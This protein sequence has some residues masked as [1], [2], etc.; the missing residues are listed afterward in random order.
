MMG[1]LLQIEM[2]RLP[3]TLRTY[4]CLTRSLLWIGALSLIQQCHAQSQEAHSV[5]TNFDYFKNT[6]LTQCPPNTTA[7]DSLTDGTIA[8]WAISIPFATQ[9]SFCSYFEGTAAVVLP[10]KLTSASF[11]PNFPSYLLQA[12]SVIVSIVSIIMAT[13]K[14]KGDLTADM[15]LPKTFW[16]LLP[17][18]LARVV[19]WWVRWVQGALDRPHAPWLSVVLWTVPWNY[20]WLFTLLKRQSAKAREMV[21]EEQQQEPL[22]HS[23]Y[24]M[25][26]D[27]NSRINAKTPFHT[28]QYSFNANPVYPPPRPSTTS[29]RTKLSS[30]LIYHLAKWG[31]PIIVIATILHWAATAVF[32]AFHWLSNSDVLSLSYASYD[33]LPLF[34]SGSSLLNASLVPGACI[35][36]LRASTVAGG[37]KNSSSGTTLPKELFQDYTG[38]WLMYIMTGQFALCCFCFFQCWDYSRNHKRRVSRMLMLSCVAVFLSLIIPFFWCAFWFRIRKNIQVQYTV[39]STDTGVDPYTIVVFDLSSKWGYWDVRGSLDKRV[40]LGL[41]GVE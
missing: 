5:F 6:G 19:A 11:L 22:Y 26:S 24:E 12:I 2:S 33:P 40:I 20:V 34:S 15:T 14:L 4:S 35:D 1:T 30:P 3:A 17:Y 29:D 32:V 8:D 27:P 7:I 21:I 18:D 41:L 37:G 36:S 38:S 9:S 39:R 10:T 28:S 13:R 31:Q 23:S 16:F 25:D